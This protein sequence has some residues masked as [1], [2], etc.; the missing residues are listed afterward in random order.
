MTR[1]QFEEVAVKIKQIGALMVIVATSFS[2]VA[3]AAGHDEQPPV[4]ITTTPADT[5]VTL[6]LSAGYEPH[7]KRPTVLP[8]L[9]V[10]LGVIQAWD[11]ASTSAAL[12]RGAREANPAAAPFVGGK[13]SMVGLKMATTAST[14]FFAERAWKKNK[15]AAVVMMAA[16]NGSMAAVSMRNMRNARR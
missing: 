4:S 9:Y 3:S 2:S 10:T 12:K 14:I 13:G 5:Y 7:V 6:P 11:I 8:A 15:V 1:R 16:I